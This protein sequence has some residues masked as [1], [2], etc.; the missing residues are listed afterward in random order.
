MSW[1]PWLMAS[2]SAVCPV[3]LALAFTSPMLKSLLTTASSSSRPPA[4]S[5]ES[6]RAE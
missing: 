2:M 4:A 6:I 1:R 3:W 5:A